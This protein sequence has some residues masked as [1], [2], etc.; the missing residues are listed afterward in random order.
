MDKRE[1][2]K[3]HV[4]KFVNLTD[5]Q[6]DYFA[7]HF[8]E[9]TFKKGQAFINEGDKVEKEYFVVCGCLKAFFINDE[10]KIYILQFAMPGGWNSDSPTSRTYSPTLTSRGSMKEMSICWAVPSTPAP[11]CSEMPQ[12]SPT[13]LS[14]ARRPATPP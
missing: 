2:L 11:C 13:G 4:S 8:K 5:E 9:H 12:A 10:T 6:I 7:A 3:Q 1:T 14:P